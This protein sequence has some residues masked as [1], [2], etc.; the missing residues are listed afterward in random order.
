LTTVLQK[1]ETANG[2]HNQIF[3]SSEAKGQR[4]T[5]FLL[6]GTK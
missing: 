6:V 4:G 3:F 2:E 1:Q 5:G